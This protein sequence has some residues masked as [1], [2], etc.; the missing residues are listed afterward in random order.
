[1][2]RHRET[3]QFHTIAVSLIKPDYYAA[4]QKTSMEALQKHGSVLITY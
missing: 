2:P 4:P 3:A 1:M